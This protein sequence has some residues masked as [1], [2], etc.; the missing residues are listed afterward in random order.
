MRGVALRAV[1]PRVRERFQ[2]LG[3]VQ[4]SKARRVETGKESRPQFVHNISHSKTAFGNRLLERG[5]AGAMI[6]RAKGFRSA[7]AERNNRLA[8]RPIG[9]RQQQP[10]SLRRQGGHVAADD[11]APFRGG[12]GERR[13]D[14][15][16][17][18]ASGETVREN[19]K[20]KR[21]IPGGIADQR[22][23]PAGLL[24]D[25]RRVLS[26]GGSGPGEKCLVAAQPGTL[27]AD[28]HKPGVPHGSMVALHLDNWLTVGLR[29]LATAL[30]MRGNS[31]YNRKNRTMRFC[32][33]TGVVAAALVVLGS[34]A[35]RAEISR[36]SKRTVVVPAKTVARLDP[37][38]G[39][40]VRTIV[41]PPRVIASREIK[42]LA[43]GEEIDGGAM[44]EK[45][46]RAA[47]S[48]VQAFVEEAARKYD[49]NPALID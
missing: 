20:P 15:A 38:S 48:N 39:Q 40:Q 19:R 36:S 7:L 13:Y 6:D 32:F 35:V 27:A 45:P 17:R 33:E 16:D 44:A 9:L 29:S 37:R 14:A 18:A 22:R 31:G 4:V 42:P 8:I 28:E 11:E 46:L 47:D 30:S 12:H 2:V 1:F 23:A 3:S 24:H 34:P 25:A 21:A 26:Q 41:V 49:V 5:K 43:I 10:Q